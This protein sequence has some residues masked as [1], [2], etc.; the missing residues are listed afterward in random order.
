M[1]KENIVCV[2]VCQVCL[3]MRADIEN[4][5]C[6]SCR[7]IWGNKGGVFMKMIRDDPEFAAKVYEI[8]YRNEDVRKMK[9]FIQT[10]GLPP[11][12]REPEKRFEQDPRR[13]F[14]VLNGGRSE[15]QEG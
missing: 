13:R 7:K 2:G 14:C 11:G 3:K 8:F 15:D 9:K 10:F 4:L 12:C 1:I 6:E 5:T